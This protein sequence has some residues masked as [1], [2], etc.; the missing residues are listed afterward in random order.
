[1]T[2]CLVTPLTASSHHVNIISGHKERASA[3]D[4]SQHIAGTSHCRQSSISYTVSHEQESP[5]QQSS[6]LLARATDHDLSKHWDSWSQH[7]DLPHDARQFLLGIDD[8]RTYDIDLPIW[9]V[10]D[11]R[12][13][14]G[15]C[16]REAKQPFRYLLCCLSHTLLKKTS[17]KDTHNLSGCSF[18]SNYQREYAISNPRRARREGLVNTSAVLSNIANLEQWIADCKTL[19]AVDVKILME[20]QDLDHSFP[21]TCELKLSLSCLI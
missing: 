16:Y 4:R 8:S 20:K 14:A 10:Q 15:T 6:P 21:V 9:V 13:P 19:A 5:R 17:V 7:D 18:N 3:L 11:S 1:M 2:Y 12:D